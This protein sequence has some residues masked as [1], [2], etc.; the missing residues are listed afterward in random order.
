MATAKRALA[1]VLPAET[2]LKVQSAKLSETLK[3]LK[4]QD[5]LLEKILVK[6]KLYFLVARN[7]HG[8]TTMAAG[9]ASAISKGSTLDKLKSEQGRTLW[10]SGENTID[11]QYKFKAYLEQNLLDDEAVD[12]IDGNF[13]I[14]DQ[15]KHVTTY[16]A[17][18]VYALVVVD[19]FQ[20]YSGNQ[21]L[22]TNGEALAITQA[23]R[24]L[25]KLKGNP[26]VLV[27]AHPVKNADQNTLVPYGGGSVVNEVDGILT[28]WKEAEIATLHHGK[29]RQASFSSFKFELQVVD[30]DLP[31]NNFNEKTSSTIFRPIAADEVVSRED[32]VYYLKVKVLQALSKCKLPYRQLAE[33]VYGECTSKELSQISRLVAEYRK[34]KL[35][36]DGGTPQLTEAGKT[37]VKENS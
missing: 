26:T 22:N 18:N 11:T 19:S 1:Q 3:S 12:V 30:L 36:R 25:T 5:Y 16:H 2:Y 21:D 35:I 7:N 4:P 24:E 31:L 15:I 33:A 17:H 32:A 23:C 8:K 27:L 28:L 9:I 37:Y 14:V 13:N 6:G 34:E 20:S 29:L 10:L